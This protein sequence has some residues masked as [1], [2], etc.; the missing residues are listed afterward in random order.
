MARFGFETTA[1]EASRVLADE[2]RGKTG[3]LNQFIYLYSHTY[4]TLVLITGVSPGGLGAEAARAI[5]LSEPG[6]LILAGRNMSKVQETEKAIN[7]TSPHVSIRCLKLDLSSQKQIREASAEVNGYKEPI[8][9]LINN[10]AIMAAPYA[11]TE[12]GLEAQFGT[13]YV[14]HYLFTNLI[15]SKILEAGK[16][17]RIVNVSSIGHIIEGIRFDDYDFSVCC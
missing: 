1:E 6:L 8:D 11:V 10:A 5:S 14:G 12:D 15:M 17:A 4:T 9:R 2:I 16:G 3:Q 13:N 7:A